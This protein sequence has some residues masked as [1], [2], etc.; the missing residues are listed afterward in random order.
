MVK[1]LFCF[2]L[3]LLHVRLIGCCFCFVLRA[4]QGMIL[5][6][7]SRAGRRHDIRVLRKSKL[8]TQIRACQ[9]GMR[10]TFKGYADRGYVTTD[11]IYAQHR[12]P[13]NTLPL[14]KGVENHVM[15]KQRVGVEW[16]NGKIANLCSFLQRDQKLRI[17]NMNI[18]NI[19]TVGCLLINS[20]TMLN[21]AGP[22]TSYWR[23]RPPLLNDYFA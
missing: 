16:V 8:Q 9:I 23:L 1:L 22:C 10:K 21:G 4:C 15:K 18:S 6:G 19:I 7:Y 20:H 13:S 14:W 12:G 2:H 5:K 11:V 3:L 17:R